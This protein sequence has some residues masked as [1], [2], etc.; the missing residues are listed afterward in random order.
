MSDT[1]VSPGKTGRPWHLWVIGIL[2]IIWNAGGAFDFT[3]TVTQWAPYMSN[4]TEE[5]LAFF[6]SFPWWQYVVWGIATWGAFLGSIALLMRHRWAVWL[7]LVS[8]IGAGVS[9]VQGMSIKDAPE[10]TGGVVFPLIII[11][12]AVLLLVYAIWLKRKGVLR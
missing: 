7:F 1:H 11:T 4:F 10:G 3:A 8:L 6:Y 2:A 5:Q 12:I 9:F